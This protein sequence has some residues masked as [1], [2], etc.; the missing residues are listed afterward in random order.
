MRW[1]KGI[2]IGG[3]V[4]L[5]STSILLRLLFGVNLPLVRIVFSL[6]FIYV[7]VRMATGKLNLGHAN[8]D[9][10]QF[11]LIG[12]IREKQSFGISFGTATLDLTEAQPP[13]S[14]SAEIEFD[15][16]LGGATIYYSPESPLEITV[17]AIFGDVKLPNGSSIFVGNLTHRTPASAAAPRK[18]RLILTVY[19]GNA[20]FQA[21]LP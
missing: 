3:F 6:G 13:A 7:G 5:F 12:E 4:A 2:L 11:R 19:C 20:Q 18:I 1:N 10:S 16:L 14:G 8:F 9:D 21:R 17:K 15:V